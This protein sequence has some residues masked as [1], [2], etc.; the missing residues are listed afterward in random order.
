MPVGVDL[1]FLLLAR[2]ITDPPYLSRR[3]RRRRATARGDFIGLGLLALGLGA[4][5]LVLDLRRAARLVQLAV[6]HRLSRSRACLALVGFVVWE[7]YHP[8]PMVDLR[9]L[10]DRNFALADVHML[11]FGA[12]LFGTTALLPLLM[13]TLLGYTATERAWRSR[14]AAW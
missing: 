12:V 2:F 3:A 8:D 11:I 13:Q 7:L 5:Q 4:L 6:H 14:P 10:R 1:A 9:V